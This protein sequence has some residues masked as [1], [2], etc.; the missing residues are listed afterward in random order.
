MFS[1]ELA[2]PA[3]ILGI[4]FL[5]KFSDILIEGTAKTAMKVG[6]SSLVISLTLVAYGTSTPELAISVTAAVEGYPEIS[7]GNVIGSNIANLL[8]IL[9]ISALIRPMTVERGII[10]RELIIM[11]GATALL[12]VVPLFEIIGVPSVVA[13]VMFLICFAAYLFYFLRSA[14]KE[15]K[16]SDS[17]QLGKTQKY[18][19]FIIGGILGVIFGAWLL[20]E[21]SVSIARFLGIPE[22]IIALTMVSVGT[23]IPELMVS[24]LS[25]YRKQSEIAIGNIIGSNIFNILLV[26]GIALLFIPM[27][28][29]T[30]LVHLSFLLVVSLLMI[31]L[32]YIGGKLSRLN[33]VF[34][35]L[36]Y[37]G[38]IRYLFL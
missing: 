19:L 6:I 33:G 20:V 18:V 24:S 36:L 29:T 15:R 34:M 28:S 12:F 7:W 31:P 21:S 27:N 11:I 37:S 9:G 26:L 14:L 1:I 4:L 17:K 8:L 3:A 38:Y 10:R 16:P 23:S 13:G 5:Y 35:L 25:A 22:I 2:V 30:S 32:M